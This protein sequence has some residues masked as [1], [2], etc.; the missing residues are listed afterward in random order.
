MSFI[1][2][3]RLTSLVSASAI[4]A[5]LTVA[6]APAATMAAE[7]D[8]VVVKG[9]TLTAMHLN[10][11]APV[12]GPINAS[13]FDIA[14]YFGP[15]HSG[16]VTAD[17]S[18]AKYYGVVA[19]GAQVNVTGS[20]VHHIGDNPFNG[21]AARQRHLLLQRRERHDQ[22]EPGLRLP[23]NGITSAARP[24]TTSI[25]PLQTSASVTNNTVT[26][27]GHIAYIAQ[28][29]IQIS[30]GAT[31]TVNKNTVSGFNYT[32]DGTVATG[33]AA[34]RRRPRQRPEQHDLRQRGEHLHQGHDRRP[35]QALAPASLRQH[36]RGLH[37]RPRSLCVLIGCEAGSSIDDQPG[38]PMVGRPGQV[39]TAR[40][41][42]PRDRSGRG[43]RCRSRPPRSS[44]SPP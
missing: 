38:H 27:E 29:G 16:T 13:G 37:G 6:A 15:G 21:V 23:E 10:P 19:D 3:R 5:T 24:P 8:T 18:G 43:V 35:R 1:T 33:P 32:P 42:W 11:T 26:G 17:I 7:G 31:A 25:P 30:Y 14:V 34:L 4:V 40:R 39:I 12:T 22:R 20:Q 36:D 2:K 9:M 41:R 28:N 44:R